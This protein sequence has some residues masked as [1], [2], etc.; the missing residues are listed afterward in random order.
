MKV[1]G[2]STEVSGRSKEEDVGPA[3]ITSKSGHVEDMMKLASQISC[4]SRLKQVVAYVC[5]C[6]SESQG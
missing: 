6:S 4:W 1:S 2:R 3:V 5:C